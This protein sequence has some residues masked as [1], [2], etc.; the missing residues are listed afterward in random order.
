M[1]ELHDIKSNFV[2]DWLSVTHRTNPDGERITEEESLAYANATAV[3]AGLRSHRTKAHSGYNNAILYENGALVQWHPNRPEMGTNYLYTGKV[4]ATYQAYDLLRNHV[5]GGGKVRRLD[6][7]IDTNA[8]L[9]IWQLFAQAKKEKMVTRSRTIPRYIEENGA[10]M[11]IGAKTSEE[12]VRIYDKR[13]EQGQPDDAPNWYRIELKIVD[14]KAVNA[15]HVLL[16]EGISVISRLIRGYVDFPSSTVWRLVFDNVE[17]TVL[18]A[19]ERKL[20]DTKAWLLTTVA[21]SLAKITKDDPQFEADFMAQWI[22]RRY[23][24]QRDQWLDEG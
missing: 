1:K 16:N 19:G 7:S 24:E 5:R 12:M 10:T 9:D 17:G 11:Y 20:S 13:A 8:P 3:L 18:S 23:P 4:L 21:N 14:D 22:H 15:A 6:I 2:I